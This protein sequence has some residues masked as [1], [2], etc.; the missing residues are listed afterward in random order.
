MVEIFKL[1]PD[2]IKAD[3]RRFWNLKYKLFYP[4]FQIEKNNYVA[5]KIPFNR[6]FSGYTYTRIIP[7][8]LGIRTPAQIVYKGALLS[9]YSI[10][11]LEFLDIFPNFS[12]LKHKRI[13]RFLEESWEQNKKITYKDIAFLTCSTTNSVFR[14]VKNCKDYGFNAAPLLTKTE[15][16]ARKSYIIE[17]IILKKIKGQLN[18]SSIINLCYE[19]YST[20]SE[21]QWIMIEFA[22]FTLA[23]N[24]KNSAAETLIRRLR[25][26]EKLLAEYTNLYNKYQ[27]F[28]ES[29]CKEFFSDCIS[30]MHPLGIL[31]KAL[32]HFCPSFGNFRNTAKRIAKAINYYYDLEKN[33]ELPDD[34]ILYNLKSKGTKKHKIL[35]SDYL[36]PVILKIID[37]VDLKEFHGTSNNSLI[38]KRISSLK[39]QAQE[40]D[41]YITYVDTCFLIS[42]SREVLRKYK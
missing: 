13:I 11:D 26:P 7:K 16:A 3:S 37:T 2:N 1:S 28:I 36:K 14:F 12:Y 10:D 32:A 29:S 24:H 15:L 25:L 27:N 35:E 21:I 20:P 42:I 18:P 33:I 39:K 31:S 8:Y 34:S 19:T 23:L 4:L 5:F 6:Y 38:E 17:Q 9:M 40:N 30:S 22:I 41:C